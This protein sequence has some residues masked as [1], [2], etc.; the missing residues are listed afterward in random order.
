MTA[1]PVYQRRQYLV[2]RRYQFHFV[3]RVFLVVL[4]VAG[5]SLLLSVALVWFNMNRPSVSS[6]TSLVAAFLAITTMMAVDL[7]VAIP[8]VFFFSIRQSHRVV[9]PMNRIKQTLEAI[10]TGNFSERI[11][12]RQGDVLED[13]AKTINRMAEDLQKRFP[14]SGTSGTS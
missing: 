2:D 1:E 5:L 9:G 3:S 14:S 10:G 6:D 12:L 13:L 4:L 7:V 11:V 8:V